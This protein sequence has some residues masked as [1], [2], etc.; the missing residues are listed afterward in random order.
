LNDAIVQNKKKKSTYPL[1]D[2]NGESTTST[3]KVSL[4]QALGSRDERKQG[5]E[6]K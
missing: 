2:E 5:Q 4:F 6:K 3:E 1:V